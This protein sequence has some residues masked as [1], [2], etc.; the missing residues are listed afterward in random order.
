MLI[1][2]VGMSILS[3]WTAASYFGFR[4]TPKGESKQV[5]CLI[6]GNKG[7]G[8]AFHNTGKRNSYFTIYGLELEPEPPK[9]ELLQNGSETTDTNT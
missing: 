9:E 1:F 5:F 3:V 7:I 4:Y 8:I 6:V 2:W